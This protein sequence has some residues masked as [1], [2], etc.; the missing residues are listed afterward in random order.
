M[1]VVPVNLLQNPEMLMKLNPLKFFQL[2]DLCNH[3]WEENCLILFLT[4]HLVAA[5]MWLLQALSTWHCASLSSCCTHHAG[6]WL[7]QFPVPACTRGIRVPFTQ[8]TEPSSG[9]RTVPLDL[10]VSGICCWRPCS[11]SA[12]QTHTTSWPFPKHLGYHHERAV[13]ATLLLIFKALSRTKSRC[14]LLVMDQWFHVQH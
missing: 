2:S 3:V 13:P 9:G 12:V 5:V 7:P 11:P 10:I 1:V 14:A 4:K 8:T 6:S